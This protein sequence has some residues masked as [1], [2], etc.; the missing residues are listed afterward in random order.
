MTQSKKNT[1][2]AENRW[3]SWKSV[4]SK[5]FTK[6]LFNRVF[7]AKVSQTGPIMLKT[8]SVHKVHATATKTKRQSIRMN[9]GSF[10]GQKNRSISIPVADLR[11]NHSLLCP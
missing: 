9:T 2:K 4:Y 3:R 7:G 11:R 1:T 8:K 10:S 6:Q 5:Q